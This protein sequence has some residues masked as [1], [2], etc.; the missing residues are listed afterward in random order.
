MES[1]P[2]NEMFQLSDHKNFQLINLQV[3]DLLD[4][5]R[6]ACYGYI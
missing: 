3:H 1:L 4:I 2:H 6:N 5:G